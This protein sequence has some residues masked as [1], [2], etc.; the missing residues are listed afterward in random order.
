LAL[1]ERHGHTSDSTGAI[2]P[3]QRVA[4]TGGSWEGE[5]ADDRT[6][7]WTEA[8]RGNAS[9]IKCLNRFL[10]VSDIENEERSEFIGPRGGEDEA[11]NKVLA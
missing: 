9:L 11:K 2:L 8:A 7:M 1:H 5:N 4:G 3:M 6:F 10:C